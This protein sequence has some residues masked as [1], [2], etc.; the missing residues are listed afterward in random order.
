MTEA[1]DG[2]YQEYAYTIKNGNVKV[3]REKFFNT[4]ELQ[5]L[6]AN[7]S[8]DQL[9]ALQR[10][11]GGHDPMKVYNAYRAAMNHR[12]GPSVVLVKTIK[13]YGTASEGNNTAHQ[14]KKRIRTA[15]DR[16]KSTN[17]RGQTRERKR[18]EGSASVPRSL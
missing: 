4:P 16:G 1:V 3:F 15:H 13:G 9:V 6:I 5:A 10:N 18:T 2:E 17:S 12:G 11:R 14:E 7:L 8:D